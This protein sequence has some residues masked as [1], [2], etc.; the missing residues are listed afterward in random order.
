MNK[1]GKDAK[2]EIL[3][4]KSKFNVLWHLLKKVSKKRKKK[5]FDIL[6]IPVLSLNNTGN[7]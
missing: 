3:K 5:Y 4:G 2:I 7:A 6:D 1:T